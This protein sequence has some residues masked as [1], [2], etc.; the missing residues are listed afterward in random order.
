MKSFIIGALAALTLTGL[1]GCSTSAGLY[2]PMVG[3]SM[4][5]VVAEIGPFDDFIELSGERRAFIYNYNGNSSCRVQL[6]ADYDRQGEAWLVREF[7]NTEK[8]VC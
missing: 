2:T 5:E 4:D 1:A 7:I 3:K 8:A 6:V